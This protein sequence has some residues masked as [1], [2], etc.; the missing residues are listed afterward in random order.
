M[1]QDT[2]STSRGRYR[3]A[4]LVVLGALGA[5]AAL[6]FSGPFMGREAQ[7]RAARLGELHCTPE[8]DFAATYRLSIETQLKFDAAALLG[9][10][11]QVVKSGAGLVGRLRVHAL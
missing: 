3:L 10:S 8:S 6:L 11:Q 7:L 5:L 9:K 4:I 2:R 1:Q